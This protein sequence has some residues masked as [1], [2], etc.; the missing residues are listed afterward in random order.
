MYKEYFGFTDVP[1]SLTPNT[2]FF[3]EARTHREALN[4]LNVALSNQDGF[5]KIV[6]EV[7]TG[8]TM[9]C[10]MLLKNLEERYVSAYIPNPYLTPHGLRAALGNEL[11]VEG[12]NTTNRHLLMS[13]ITDRLI[14]LAAEGRQA[15]MVIDEAQAMP[16]ETLEALRLIT[17]LETE[18]RKLLQVVLFGQPELDNLMARQ[19]LRQLRQ[20]VIFSY[21]LRTLDQVSTAA[22]IRHRI[23][24]AGYRGDPLLSLGAEDLIFRASGG[25]PRLINV[26]CH[27]AL[28]SAYGKGARRIEKQHVK[29]AMRDTDGLP[30]MA[31]LTRLGLRAA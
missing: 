16:V 31:W 17:N 30:R 5:I 24:V 9:L 22:Y 6:G 4:V 21:Q 8:K 12:S 26:L 19:D 25:V 11:G 14:A 28:L 20:R 18:H 15:V 1:F 29:A 10:R 3:V 13:R 7:G 2:Q 23:S 27:K